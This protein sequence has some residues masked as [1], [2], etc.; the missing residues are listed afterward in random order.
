MHIILKKCFNFS[1]NESD[2]AAFDSM[3]TELQS[4][5]VENALDTSLEN[6]G[7]KP[8]T[9][10]DDNMENSGLW[11]DKKV[12]YVFSPSVGKQI[13]TFPPQNFHLF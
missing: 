6:V 4:E 3:S 9:K 5:N 8:F 7:T 10:N 1:D 11:P 13:S 12:Y 2:N